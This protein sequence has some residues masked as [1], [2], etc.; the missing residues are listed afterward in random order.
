MIVADA[1]LLTS[2]LAHRPASSVA[3]AVLSHDADWCAPALWRFELHNALLK[4]VRAQMLTIA[5]SEVIVGRAERLIAHRE[6]QAEAGAVLR[7]AVTHRLSA[8]DAQ[9]VAL[10]KKLGIPLVTLDRR[11]ALAVPNV[12]LLP[13]DYLL[14]N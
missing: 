7:A 13:A 9:Y 2:L 8:Y 12:A 5:E 14:R 6:Q 3:D 1:S 4:Y 11:L 10:A